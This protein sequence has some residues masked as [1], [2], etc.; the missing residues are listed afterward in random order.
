MTIGISP[1]VGSVA[2][3]AASRSAPSAD[4]DTSSGGGG[5][6]VAKGAAAP[7]DPIM[8]SPASNAGSLMR[9][10]AVGTLMS[11]P[12]KMESSV[13]DGS[14]PSLGENGP[15]VAIAGGIPAGA[16]D[17]PGGAGGCMPPN[18]IGGGGSPG[19]GAGKL[20]IGG[21]GKPGGGG[22]NPAPID[23]AIASDIN[24]NEMSVSMT[25]SSGGGG[26]GWENPGAPPGLNGLDGLDI[27]AREN[28]LAIGDGAKGD[29]PGVGARGG[30]TIWLGAGPDGNGPGMAARW[31]A[32]VCWSP[33][34]FVAAGEA[35]AAGEVGEAWTW[36]VGARGGARGDE[37]GPVRPEGGGCAGGWNGDGEGAAFWGAG[38][39]GGAGA[40][41]GGDDG[42]GADAAAPPLG[43]SYPHAKHER[44]SATRPH[45]GQ[46]VSDMGTRFHATQRAGN[47]REGSM[48]GS[49]ACASCET[50]ADT[51]EME[52]R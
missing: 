30:G 41:D 52:P 33:L 46:R 21:G 17:I 48:G 5:G 12:S 7:V 4:D 51:L 10:G 26:G 13:L 38:A 1:S 28:G 39:D 18:A 22:G 34:R 14:A 50:H 19:G 24:E 37:K 6:G 44:P 16:A 47:K 15:A 23:G 27:G 42:A 25:I 40:G 49:G 8:K 11:M 2:L 3:N 36:G 35:G 32:P 29:G 9:A 43:H 20:A 45:C 31:S